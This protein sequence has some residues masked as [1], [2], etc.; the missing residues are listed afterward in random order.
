MTKKLTTAAAVL[1]IQQRLE[2]QGLRLAETIDNDGE[3]SGWSVE[4][5]ASSSD[6]G[7]L[8]QVVVTLATGDVATLSRRKGARA[9]GRWLVERAEVR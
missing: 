3:L 7:P 1:I 5:K 2:K 4:R 6:D 9:R 8:F